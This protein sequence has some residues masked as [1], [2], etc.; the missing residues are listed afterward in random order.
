MTDTHTHTQTHDDGIYR[1][2]TASR[3]KNAIHKQ[4]AF[5][6]CWAHSP[7]RAAACP[8]FTLPFTRCRYCR[9]PPLLHAACASM[10][11]TTTTTTTTTCDR[12][13][14][15]GPI[16]LTQILQSELH[17]NVQQS[18]KG[19]NS[20]TIIVTIKI[21]ESQLQFPFMFTHVFHKLRKTNICT[22]ICISFT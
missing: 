9:T 14:R 4:E 16:E 22:L 6:K 2:S 1:V 21:G 15:Y 10:S 13:D 7:L 18:Y 20:H 5:E 8:N 19:S 3:G 17:D 12:K 11:T